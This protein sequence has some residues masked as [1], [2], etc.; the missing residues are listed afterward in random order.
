M[1]TVNLKELC[2]A[3]V[4]RASRVE[5]RAPFLSVLWLEQ[6]PAFTL[7]MPI[8]PQLPGFAIPSIPSLPS[9]SLAISA[10][11]GARASS[12]ASF[13]FSFAPGLLVDTLS[14]ASARSGPSPLGT[15]TNAA[16]RTPAALDPNRSVL[17]HSPRGTRVR[18][19]PRS[20]R[21]KRVHQLA[22]DSTHTFSA[23]DASSSSVPQNDTSVLDQTGYDAEEAYEDEEEDDEFEWDAVDRMRLWRHDA[24][25]QHLYD[26]AVFWGD[27]VLSWTSECLPFV[28]CG[29]RN[30]HVPRVSLLLSSFI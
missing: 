16:R 8:T 20:A 25:M 4:G 2:G 14:A 27:K 24:L 22:R 9:P 1:N 12:N 23:A 21:H 19:D 10:R 6:I 3:R 29:Q 15:G 13:S 26:T 17:G 7:S 5:R 28:A 30:E 18:G 11:P